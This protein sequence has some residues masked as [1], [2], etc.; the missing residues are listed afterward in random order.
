MN[1]HGRSR[2]EILFKRVQVI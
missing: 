2:Y 1:V